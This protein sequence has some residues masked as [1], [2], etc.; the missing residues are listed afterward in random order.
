M[1]DVRKHLTNASVHSAFS[2]STIGAAFLTQSV[3]VDG[4]TV[5]FEIWDTAGQ[6]RYSSLAP[7]VRVAGRLFHGLKRNLKPY[8]VQCN[9]KYY[10]GAKAGI[11]AYDITSRA[12]FDRAKSWVTELQQSGSAGMVI[13]LAGNKADMSTQREV[14]E[15]EAQAYATEM[16][17]LFMETSAKTDFNVTELFAAVAKKLPRA[18]PADAGQD[19]ITL[20]GSEEN[21]DACAC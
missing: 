21:K 13:A 10:R 14:P 18:A 5:K 20:G 16:G 12:S 1:C 8:S 4:D 3:I 17:L 7:M 15:E 9:Q 11:V 2:E 19:S 6:E